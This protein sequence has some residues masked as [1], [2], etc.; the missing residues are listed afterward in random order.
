MGC[1]NQITKIISKNKYN[2]NF[3]KEINEK[4]YYDKPRSFYKLP[5][6]V[7]IG[8]ASILKIEPP[9]LKENE[10]INKD[11]SKV[12]IKEKDE[13]KCSLE[14]NSQLNNSKIKNQFGKLNLHK[15][16]NQLDI[17]NN[18]SYRKDNRHYPILDFSKSDHSIDKTQENIL[19]MK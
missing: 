12:Q 9:K 13:L 8:F 14:N 6:S 18:I 3:F 5:D 10:K 1:N 7:L 11:R 4:F 17:S 16:P 15:L 2:P 19:V